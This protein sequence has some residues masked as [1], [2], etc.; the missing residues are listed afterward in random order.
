VYT[1]I[2]SV[3]LSYKRIP[4]TEVAYTNCLTSS[5]NIFIDKTP[6]PSSSALFTYLSKDKKLY[7]NSGLSLNKSIDLYNRLPVLCQNTYISTT[8]RLRIDCVSTAY[9]LR[10]TLF[11]FRISLPFYLFPYL[12]RVYREALELH[13]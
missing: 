3:T 2:I 7:Y 1:Y 12:P 4:R 8:Y 10:I 9:H 6:V 11:R 5:L 13:L